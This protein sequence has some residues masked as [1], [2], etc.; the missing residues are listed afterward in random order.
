VANILLITPTNEIRADLQNWSSPHIGIHRIASYL[1][2]KDH[3]AKVWDTILDPS[4]PEEQW[5][6]IG[7]S[8]TH[9]T[10]PDDLVLMRKMG[11]AYPDATLVAGGVEA[12]VNYQQIFESVPRLS[13]VIVGEGEEPLLALADGNCNYLDYTTSVPGSIHREYQQLSIEQFTKY[14]LGMDFKLMRHAEHWAITKGINPSA[15]E[16]EVHCVRLNTSSFCPRSC[17]FCSVT[18]IH[19]MSTGKM[20]KPITMSSKDTKEL[21]S[22]VKRDVP[23]VHTIY[24]NDDDFCIH[25]DKAEMFFED[26]PPLRYL[27]QAR[28]DTV[29]RA[30][31]THMRRGGCQQV[32]FGLENCS[33]KVVD[34]IG[35]RINVEKSLE[36]LDI[37]LEVGIKPFA[38]IILFCPTSTI[39]DMAINYKRLSELR[40]KKIGIS[41]MSFIR[42]YRGTYYFNSTHDIS[43]EKVKGIKRPVAVLPDDLDVRSMF[44]EFERRL[45]E[46]EK[47]LLHRWK[48]NT[49]SLMIEVLG[50][51]LREKGAL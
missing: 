30:L 44:F 39:E 41:I 10:L 19:K 46:K 36:I 13:Y 32:S 28:T 18:F 34:S 8:I 23:S 45:A 12:C 6:I 3:N 20:C 21:V 29:D 33:Q 27:I 9:D 49:S 40:E 43:W 22:K 7:F 24:F 47:Q 25:R 1:R 38:L 35:K 42:A 48:G 5:D 31:L 15:S 16:I 37:C 17:K 11:A 2:S 4:Y 51:V 26:P 14:N 50:N